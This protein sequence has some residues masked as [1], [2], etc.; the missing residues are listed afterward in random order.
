M[1]Q[2]V[3]GLAATLEDLIL[4]LGLP[5]GR[6]KPAPAGHPLTSTYVVGHMCTHTQAHIQ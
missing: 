1:V 2:W 3:E 4:F 6:R 5:G